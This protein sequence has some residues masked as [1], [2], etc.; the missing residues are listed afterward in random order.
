MYNLSDPMDSSTTM[1]WAGKQIGICSS[2]HES[3]QNKFVPQGS[4]NYRPQRL[5]DVQEAHDSNVCLVEISKLL[6]ENVGS[7][8]YVALSYCWCEN[9]EMSLSKNHEKL[10]SIDLEDLPRNF[11]YA[12]SI[13]RQINVRYLWIESLCIQQDSAHESETEMAY[14]GLIYV[15]VKCVISA[16]ASKDSTSSCSVL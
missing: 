8:Q 11:K 15:N 6:I 12:V 14:M 9:I 7:L 13:A 16:T 2:D 4:T 5:I 3:C 10:Q 1:R